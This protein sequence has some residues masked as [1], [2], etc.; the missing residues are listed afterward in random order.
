MQLPSACST[1][2]QF[3]VDSVPSLLFSREL[4]GDCRGDGDGLLLLMR[5]SPAFTSSSRS[6]TGTLPENFKQFLCNAE[7][8]AL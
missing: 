1:R 6:W 8:M 4:R 3:S 2:A 7:D 5:C